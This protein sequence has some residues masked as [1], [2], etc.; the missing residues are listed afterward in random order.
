MITFLGEGRGG[1]IFTNVFNPIVCSISGG[2]SLYGEAPPKRGTFFTLQVYERV[3]I[4]E[5]KNMKG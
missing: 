1:M 2:Y 3:E 5:S 4:H